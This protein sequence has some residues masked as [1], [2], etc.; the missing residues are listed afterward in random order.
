MSIL[1]DRS[2]RGLAVVL[3]TLAL[4]GCT[5]REKARWSARIADVPLSTRFVIAGDAVVIPS[6]SDDSEDFLSCFAISDGNPR[7]QVPLGE[8]F[9]IGSAVSGVA[10]TASPDGAAVYASQG[11]TVASFSAAD[12]ARRW[13]G[14]VPEKEP[15]E[16][17]L[18]T[19]KAVGERLYL[20]S[21]ESRVVALDAR[22][23]AVVLQIHDYDAAWDLMVRAGT[24]ITRSRESSDVRAHDAETGAPLWQRTMSAAFPITSRLDMSLQLAPDTGPYL[25]I[26]GER[27]LLALDPRT[28]ALR[29]EEKVV[30]LAS[31]ASAGPV[32]VVTDSSSVRALDPA[33]GAAR[34]RHPT[35]GLS[36][37]APLDDTTALLAL[38]TGIATVDTQTGAIRQHTRHTLQEQDG[39]LDARKGLV[40]LTTGTGVARLYQRDGNKL[41]ERTLTGTLSLPS[42]LSSHGLMQAA[43][44]AGGAVT[45]NT[46]HKLQR[47][48]R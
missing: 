47:F 9:S 38:S 15:F 23:G 44:A 16:D 8:N 10:L 27:A 32:V 25:V 45:F 17:F 34:W 48:A 6:V 33:T 41:I 36:F 28:G 1:R 39:I 4:A 12:G 30:G 42:A 35:G 3:V 40:V 11:T 29:W 21:D 46:D 26:D 14:R 24:V 13:Y 7:W 18:P 43:I 31:Y 19:T 37:V 22:T 5:G 2:A 20:L